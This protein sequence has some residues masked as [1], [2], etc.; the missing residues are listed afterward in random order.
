[1]I[2]YIDKMADAL[3]DVLKYSDSS[4]EWPDAEHVAPDPNI[5]PEWFYPALQ[6]TD[7][8]EIFAILLYTQQTALYDDEIGDLV[9]GVGIVEMKHFANI[10]DTVVS[11]GGTIPQ[12]FTDKKLDLGKD[13]GDALRIDVQ[14]E[15]DTIQLYKSIKEK[16]TSQS[17]TAKTL[18]QMLDK[19]IADETLHLKL[20]YAELKKRNLTL[21]DSN[22]QNNIHKL[23]PDLDNA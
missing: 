18:Q 15:Y 16:I 17:E 20:F 11:L 14:G 12:A 19:L 9:L 21:L 1:M 13:L 2:N 7:A 22:L 23:I 4:V 10:R 3:V 5:K 8:S 6:S